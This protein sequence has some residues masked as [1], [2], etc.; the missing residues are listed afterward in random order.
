MGSEKNIKVIY[1][2]KNDEV[3][4]IKKESAGLF[5]LSLALL[6]A[7]G[8][9]FGAN[10]CFVS[11]KT[12]FILCF[13]FYGSIMVI[14]CL[15]WFGY[16]L[17]KTRKRMF[18]FFNL[19]FFFLTIDSLIISSLVDIIKN[20]PTGFGGGLSGYYI[21]EFLADNL[22]H[23]GAWIFA[24]L[25]LSI[26]LFLISGLSISMFLAELSSWKKIKPVTKE[27]IGSGES[28]STNERCPEYRDSPPP[29]RARRIFFDDLYI[30]DKEISATKLSLVESEKKEKQISMKLSLPPSDL[31][32]WDVDRKKRPHFA[33]DQSAKLIATLNNFGIQAKILDIHYGPVITRYD[34]QPAPGIKV[35]RIVNLADDLA[36]ALAAKG[37]RIEAPIPGK[38]AVG[39]EVPNTTS[40]LVPFSELW[41]YSGYRNSQDGLPVVLGKDIAGGIV[42]ADLAQMPHLLIAGTTG[43]GKSVCINTIIC[44][45]LGKCSPDKVRFIMIDPKMVELASYNNIPHLLTP[46]VKDA[47]RAAWVLKWIVKQMEERYN[48]LADKGARDIERY[49]KMAGSNDRINY[50]VIII[51]EL[52]DLMMAAP[53][54][55]EDSICRL[56]QMARSVGIHLVVATQRPSVDVITGLIKA[57]IPTRIAFAVSS[58]VD[59]RTILDSVG[60]EKLLGRGDMLFSPVGSLKPI[61]MQGALITENQID[62]IVKYWCM[63][64]KPQYAEIN[65][66]NPKTVD[67]GELDDLFFEAVKI[68]ADFGQASSSLLQRKLHIGYARAARLIDQLEEKG[69]IGPFEG[70]K[71]RE[72]FKSAAQLQVIIQKNSL[73]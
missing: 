40:E 34:L 7:A 15:A 41:H 39:I 25:I 45:L 64:Q 68:V 57:N 72:I 21:S 62:A 29:P 13:G 46:V 24:G 23:T 9:L 56:A 52:A 67:G 55:V 20:N 63:Q 32:P 70:S 37:L 48:A 35:S 66:E 60:A 12:F 36:L 1:T 3:G 2:E 50:I 38:A 22:S 47:Q 42:M 4:A 27:I 8:F 43:S 44:S 51:D 73:K 16:Y 14:A 71:P 33:A 6:G 65:L 11:I 49:N 19:G 69:I 5:L 59:S 53:D 18:S 10:C 61:R 54:E 28:P 17:I 26:A 31:L 30:N 58:Q